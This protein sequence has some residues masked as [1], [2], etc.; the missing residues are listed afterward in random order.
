MTLFLST[1]INKVDR[2]GRVSVPAA[3]RSALIGSDGA[4]GLVLVRSNG[5]ECLEGFGL[6]FMQDISARLDNFDLFSAEQ[7]DLALSVFGDSVQLSLDGDGRVI[8]PEMLIDYAGI[9]GEAAFVG[10]GRKFQIWNPASLA[11]RKDAAR[12]AV[13][14]NGL[15]IPKGGADA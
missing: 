7:D 15:T 4:A 6:S 5:Y 2:K 13:K 10:L 8:L 3:F 11:A 1:Y 9:D 14:D 12:L